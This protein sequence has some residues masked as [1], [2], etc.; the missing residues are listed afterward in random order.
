M[1][2]IGRDAFQEALL[3]VMEQK[4]H[5]SNQ[6]FASGGV[7]REKMHIH[8]EQEFAVFVRDFP[9]LVGRAYVQCPIP[10]VRRS[11]AENLYEEETGAIAAGRPHPELFLLIPRGFGCDMARFESIA[12][13]PG[14][15]QY[16]DILDRCTL[17]QGWE[18][19]AAVTTLFIEGTAWERGELDCRAPKRPMPPLEQHPL[20][21]HYGLGLE[22][23]ELPR[24]HR[25]VEGGHRQAAW[26][27]IL[28]HV[29][30]AVRPK[31]LHAMR[32]ALGGWLA[33]KDSVARAVGLK[34]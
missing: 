8:F 16:R 29:D 15:R 27:A 26:R 12:L 13:L 10:T 21:V 34:R 18:V 17:R 32:D 6:A 2:Q 7:A 20:H 19:A 28:D 14:S 1:A 5:W 23:L 9:V 11:L 3:T 30:E 22:Y 25:N 24:I 4:T 31:V 33:Y